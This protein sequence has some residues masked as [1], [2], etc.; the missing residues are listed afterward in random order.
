[1]PIRYSDIKHTLIS[2]A[3][4]RSTEER[5][6]VAEDRAANA[7]ADLMKALERIKSLERK[8][9]VTPNESEGPERPE[10]VATEASV[11]KDKTAEPE[12]EKPKVA[13]EKEKEKRSSSKASNK[14][15]KK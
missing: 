15:K 11:S 10:S 3:L 13:K 5:A 4:S 14:S 8:V 2:A 12:K 9:A 1:M 6:Q 7:E